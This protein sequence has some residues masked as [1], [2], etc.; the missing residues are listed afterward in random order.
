[1]IKAWLFS[2]L[3][4]KLSKQPWFCVVKLQRSQLKFP[5]PWNPE[6][7]LNIHLAVHEFCPVVGSLT[8]SADLP[9]KRT[10]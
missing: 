10:W 8:K 5:C 7:I 1:M 2:A 6:K 4:L 9:T 3:A